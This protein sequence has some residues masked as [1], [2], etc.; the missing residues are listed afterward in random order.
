MSFY[1][2]GDAFWFFFQL[3]MWL[4]CNLLLIGG[5]FLNY[6]GEDSVMIIVYGCLF[7]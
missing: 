6:E 5:R 3:P 4:L 2:R 1:I 7:Y